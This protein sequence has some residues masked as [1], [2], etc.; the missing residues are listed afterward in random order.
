MSLGS[1]KEAAYFYKARHGAKDLMPKGDGIEAL[2][3]KRVK[4][5]RAGIKQ[6]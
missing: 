2:V 3:Q 5:S 4:R 1:K 6:L